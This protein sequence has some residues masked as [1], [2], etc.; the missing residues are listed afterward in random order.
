M[1]KIAIEEVEQVLLQHKVPDA[2]KII[3]DL[4]AI[5]EELKADREANAED[6]PKYEFVVILND[7]NN[8]LQGLNAEDEVTAYVVQ[9]EEGEDAGTIISK[10]SDAAVAQNETAKTKRGRLQNAREVF[11]GLK[12]KFLKDKKLKIKTKEPVRILVGTG[13]L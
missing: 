13:K 4:E 1:S 10:I 11:E 9:Q 2:P 6:R 7:P 5:I 12:P 3:E 8:K